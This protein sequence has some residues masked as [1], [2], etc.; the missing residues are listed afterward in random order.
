MWSIGGG[1]G[2]MFLL[3][4]TA[5]QQEPDEDLQC[6]RPDWQNNGMIINKLKL[7]HVNGV[8]KVD[9]WGGGG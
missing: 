6:R 1:G 7:R 3:Y 8:M 5:S 9:G 2:G 4:S